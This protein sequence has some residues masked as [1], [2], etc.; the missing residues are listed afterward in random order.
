[1]PDEYD[2]GFDSRDSFEAFEADQPGDDE[3]QERIELLVRIE[4]AEN[5][6]FMRTAE[7]VKAELEQFAET[8]TMGGESLGYSFEVLILKRCD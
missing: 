2:D 6:E 1:M 4:P 8:M 3:P 7:E 5:G